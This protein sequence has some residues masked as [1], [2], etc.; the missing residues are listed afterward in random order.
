M[1]SY[2]YLSIKLT[3]FFSLIGLCKQKVVKSFF[4]FKPIQNLTESYQGN[5][6][7]SKL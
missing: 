7:I 5:Q 1:G 4:F 2:R 3:D 6:G